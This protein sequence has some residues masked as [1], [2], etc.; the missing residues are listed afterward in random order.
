MLL[1]PMF[2]VQYCQ[3][4]SI[5]QSVFSNSYF[6]IVYEHITS[7]PK[8]KQTHFIRRVELPT[9]V[10]HFVIVYILFEWKRISTGYPLFA[11]V[12]S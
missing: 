2:S 1:L 7:S 4:L 12:L 10:L 3:C 5:V 9:V 8:I 6:L 11:S